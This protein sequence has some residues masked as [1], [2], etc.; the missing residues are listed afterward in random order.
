MKIELENLKE[1]REIE[2][3]LFDKDGKR[4]TGVNISDNECEIML[5]AIN[6]LELYIEDIWKKLIEKANK[7]YDLA[8]EDQGG[9]ELYLAIESL[10]YRKMEAFSSPRSTNPYSFPEKNRLFNTIFP[11]TAI[12]HPLFQNIWKSLN[13]FLILP[14]LLSRHQ[15]ESI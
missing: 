10:S 12:L 9:N 13:L 1:F 8:K 3:E 5:K 2:Y 6:E 11:L 14:I 15:S 4:Y 7:T